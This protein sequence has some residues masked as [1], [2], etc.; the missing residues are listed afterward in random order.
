MGAHASNEGLNGGWNTITGKTFTNCTNTGRIRIYCRVRF[1]IG[2]VV[3]YSENDI[4]NCSCTENIYGYTNGGIGTVGS[5]YHRNIIGGVVGL[6]TGSTISSSKFQGTL[7]SYG[8]SPFAYDGGIIGYT[9]KFNSEGT[10]ITLS[11]CKVGGGTIRGAG[12]GQG[13]CALMVNNSTNEVT[14]TFTDCVIKKSTVSYATGSKVTISSSDNV[15]E[16]Q[17]FG[18]GSSGYTFNGTLPTVVTSID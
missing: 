13:R 10:S 5:N 4:S 12:S 1:C 18:G 9:Y 17:C 6:F 16:A 2:G 3:A 15:S 8:S 11:G 7:N 14:Y